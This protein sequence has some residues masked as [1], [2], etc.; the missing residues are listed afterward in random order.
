MEYSKCNSTNVNE[1]FGAC[2]LDE[3]GFIDK[4]ELAAVSDLNEKEVDEIFRQL[5]LD[6]D[7]RISVEEF[8]KSF[9]NFTDVVAEIKSQK[10]EKL[11]DSQKG[12]LALK[13]ELG[14]EGS[15]V[16]R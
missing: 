4:S 2:D 14:K 5:D 16:A 6:N 10:K 7:G 8:S 13:N 11:A 9:Q 3:S 1:L 15:I 12:L